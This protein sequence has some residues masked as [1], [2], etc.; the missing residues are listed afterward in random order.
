MSGTAPAAIVTTAI[1]ANAIVPALKSNDTLRQAVWG[2]GTHY[3]GV[4]GADPSWRP[5]LGM[6]LWSAE[7]YSTYV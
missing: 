1:N 5:D 6:T 2:L 3:P 7:D 4:R